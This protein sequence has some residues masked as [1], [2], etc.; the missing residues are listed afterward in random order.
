[1]DAQQVLAQATAVATTI[2]ATAVPSATPTPQPAPPTSLFPTEVGYIITAILGALTT[3]VVSRLIYGIQRRDQFKLE[4][5]RA[6]REKA[7][8]E[9]RVQRE[10]VAAEEQRYRD[11]RHEI[12]RKQ[13]EIQRDFDQR[14]NAI[15]LAILRLERTVH[16]IEGY[17]DPIRDAVR[18]SI[19]RKLQDDVP[20]S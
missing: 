15:N 13:E 14:L 20:G 16:E 11:W 10:K 18:L 12:E 3:Y 6:E 1:M 17:I 19:R 9:E 7:A 8:G 4:A 2:V 5:Q